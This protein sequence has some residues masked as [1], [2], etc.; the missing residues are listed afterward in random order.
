MVK[1]TQWVEGMIGL[2]KITGRCGAKGGARYGVHCF[3]I[4]YEHNSII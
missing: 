1:R 3:G 2:Q 4:L